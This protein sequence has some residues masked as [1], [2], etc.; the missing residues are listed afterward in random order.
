MKVKFEKLKAAEI[1]LKFENG[2]ICGRKIENREVIVCEIA[3][4]GGIFFNINLNAKEILNLNE[5]KI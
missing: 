3:L 5:R 4:R 1:R 2:G